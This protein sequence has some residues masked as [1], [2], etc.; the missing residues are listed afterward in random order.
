MLEGLGFKN[1][2]NRNVP[3]ADAPA[4]VPRTPGADSGAP[5]DRDPATGRRIING[6]VEDAPAGA[7]APSTSPLVRPSSYAVPSGVPAADSA[8]SGYTG[9]M[10]TLQGDRAKAIAMMES[11]QRT[12]ETVLTAGEYAK[13]NRE[14]EDALLKAQ[15]LP[16]SAESLKERL[17]NLATAG[18]EARN[19]RDV[20][21]WMAAA[22]GFFAMAGGKSQYAMQNMAE[23]LN[24]G[25]K[26]LRAV[27]QDYRK[28][29]QLQKDKAELLKEAARQEARG[30]VAK[31]QT[32]RKEAEDRNGKIADIKLRTGAHLLETFDRAAATATTAEGN[33]QTRADNAAA[34]AQA[35]EIAAQERRDRAAEVAA[36][37]TEQKE[38]DRSLKLQELYQKARFQDPAT[39]TLAGLE[40]EIAGMGPR[41]T[42]KPKDQQKYDE[43]VATR[44]ATAQRIHTNAVGVAKNEYSDDADLLNSAA[45]IIKTG[46]Q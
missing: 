18:R 2:V 26:E 36:G 12:P 42:L 37:K 8:D 17:A 25:V 19:N 31:G 23:G 41:D 30:D 40:S 46:K 39:K 21:R 13:K 7:P 1:L 35:A 32:L 14:E 11:G 28:I 5:T 16:T 4:A 33:R 9:V 44:D 15:G 29:D 27:E 38:R 43:K 45:R 10:K 6:R 22:Q 24:I 20:D 34:R 3:A